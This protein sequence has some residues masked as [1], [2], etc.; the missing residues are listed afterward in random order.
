MI[1]RTDGAFAGYVTVLWRSVYPPFS[2]ANIP[3]TSD[4]NVLPPLRGRGFGSQLMDKAEGLIATRSSLVGVAVGLHED[5][6]AAQRLYVQRGYVPDGRG[7]TSRRNRVVFGES[8]TADDDLVL[9]FTK[10][11]PSQGGSVGQF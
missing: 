4:L 9:W 11:L 5:Y 3:E 2:Q 7:I 10:T 6:G 1:A 8:V